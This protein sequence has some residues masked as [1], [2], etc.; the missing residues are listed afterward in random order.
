MNLHILFFK[1]EQGIA[2]SHN[3]PEAPLS[4]FSELEQCGTG[5]FWAAQDRGDRTLTVNVMPTCSL[6][7]APGGWTRLHGSLT[8]SVCPGAWHTEGAALVPPGQLK[9]MR[10]CCVWQK[11]MNVTQPRGCHSVI[12]SLQCSPLPTIH[13]CYLGAGKSNNQWLEIM[14]R[15][16]VVSETEHLPLKNIQRLKKPGILSD[17]TV[18]SLPIIVSG[19]T[20]RLVGLHFAGHHA[21]SG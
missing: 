5:P 13:F 2:N 10:L 17:T 21:F 15:V 9:V 14:S 8:A 1:T 4:N 18:L 3:C 11:L 6:I 16:M 20:L 12:V 19:C 7:P